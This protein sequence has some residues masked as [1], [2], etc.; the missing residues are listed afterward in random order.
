MP[1]GFYGH[2]GSAQVR[3]RKVTLEMGIWFF[4]SL[5]IRDYYG[6]KKLKFVYNWL[7]REVFLLVMKQ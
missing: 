5:K 1:S 7:A 3:A 6:K 4:L 2:D